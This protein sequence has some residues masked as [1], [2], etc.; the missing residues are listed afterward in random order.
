V[1]L[2]YVGL[3]LL[4][5]FILATVHA[6]GRVA[7]RDPKRG[8]FLLSIA[9]YVIVTNFIESK[10]MQGYNRLWLL[11]L[12]TAVETGRYCRYLPPRATFGPVH[13]PPAKKAFPA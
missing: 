3:V 2:G 8:W 7:D 12:F 6:I 5:I 10:W 9:L 1:D 4:V 11:F 13:R